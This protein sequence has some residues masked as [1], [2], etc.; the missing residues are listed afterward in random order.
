MSGASAS[1]HALEL[2]E[3]L[4]E[5][6]RE[7][8]K[9]GSLELSIG[10]SVGIET[11]E[12]GDCDVERIMRRA[13]LALYRAKRDGRNCHRVFD[14]QMEAEFQ[15]KVALADELRAA[16]VAGDLLLHYQPIVSAESR[17]VVGME[18]LRALAAPYPRL[19]IARC[20]FRL[21]RK[22]A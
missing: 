18:A 16:I 5:E 11:I 22:W 6:V 1:A 20:S 4:M 10:V 19:D 3:R 8:F 17:E 7:P 14:A 9:I 2:A 12:P 13:D 21:P 15:A